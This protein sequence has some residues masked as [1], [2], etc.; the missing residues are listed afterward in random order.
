MILLLIT[1]AKNDTTVL[2]PN[3]RN[4]NTHNNN[5]CNYN[6]KFSINYI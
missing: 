2:I 6:L 1:N 4:V 3:T 5:L